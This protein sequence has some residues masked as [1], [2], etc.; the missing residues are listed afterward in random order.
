ML[1]LLQCGE[2]LDRKMGF[3]TSTQHVESSWQ[4]ATTTPSSA[5]RATRT[6]HPPARAAPSAPAS[7]G[8]RGRAQPCHHGSSH[9]LQSLE[10]SLHSLPSV[11]VPKGAGRV[12][13]VGGKE[14]G[15][16][17]PDRHLQPVATHCRP[18]AP[19]PCGQPEH[20]CLLACLSACLSACLPA[21]LPRERL[22]SPCR[23][24]RPAPRSIGASRR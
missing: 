17:T 13:E 1:H 8:R 11:F 21:C 6:H 22:G 12:G 4:H 20:V 15:A 14:G 10:H 5:P 3:W 18:L 2:S 9:P 19:T 7:L 24:R 16:A 23:A